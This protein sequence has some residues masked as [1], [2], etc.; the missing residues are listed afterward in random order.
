EAVEIVEVGKE[1]LRLDGMIERGAGCFERLFQILQHIGCLQLD[2]RAVIGK[3]RRPARL[4]R[5]TLLEV[6]CQLAR[7]KDEVAGDERLAI[8]GKRARGA[9][10]YDPD[11]HSLTHQLMGEMLQLNS[12]NCSCSPGLSACETRVSP[13]GLN[14]GYDYRNSSSAWG[15]CLRR[16][17]LP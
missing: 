5:N 8:I 1:D 10:S 2:I 15:N 14:P 3:A 6:A 4:R 16:Q 17:R 7:G 9:R 12:K 11:G 13:D